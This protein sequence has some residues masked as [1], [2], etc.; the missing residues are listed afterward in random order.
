MIKI[1]ELRIGNIVEYNGFHLPVYSI[2]GA[3]PN[4]DCRYNDK[5]QVDL[6]C[7]GFVTV[8]EDEIDPIP[9]TPEILTRCE[10]KRDKYGV[11]SLNCIHI[12]F[13]REES[14]VSIYNTDS[15][16]NIKNLHQ[17]QNLYYMMYNKDMEV[18]L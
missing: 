11:Y 18:K 17:L 10:F 1:N 6:V 15:L 3:F 12:F 14:F 2:I 8:N 4:E 13:K 5:A 16:Y 9:I 7:D